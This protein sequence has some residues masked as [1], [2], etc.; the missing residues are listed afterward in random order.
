MLVDFAIEAMRRGVDRTTAII[1][2]GQKR[3]RPII[4]TTIAMV[5]GMAPSALAI[6]AGGE[7]RS[8]MAIAVIGGLI[9][10]TL[11]SLLFV[12]AF[13]TVMDDVGRLFARVFGRL[14]GPAGDTG[15][16]F[17][18][19]MPGAGVQP[20]PTATAVVQ[21]ARARPAEIAANAARHAAAHFGRARPERRPH[22]DLRQHR[23][24]GPLERRRA[25]RPPVRAALRPVHRRRQGPGGRH[26]R[27][28]LL[29]PRARQP[30]QPGRPLPARPG[31][32]APATGSASCSTR[33]STATW[34]CWRC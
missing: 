6:G 29:V 11:L 32:S 2:A 9:V 17:A 28:H 34:R 1:E 5:A 15:L 13:F 8:P 12:P 31:A 10:S 20:V 25:A 33:P 23:Q 4:M 27:R 7:F 16:A 18:G 24:R 3:A 14:A 26:R 22:P 21:A 19:A 30:R